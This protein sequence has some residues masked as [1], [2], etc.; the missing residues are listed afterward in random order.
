MWVASLH[1]N[2]TTNL[3]S[4][5]VALYKI[6]LRVGIHTKVLYMGMYS[7]V[8]NSYMYKSNATAC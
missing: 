4:A 1:A 6:W 3:I 2:N 8:T 7:G 5:Y